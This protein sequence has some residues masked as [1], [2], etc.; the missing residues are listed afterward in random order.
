M[1]AVVQR[2]GNAEVRVE[3]EVVGAIQEGLVVLLGVGEDDEMKDAEYLADKI[4]GLR[5]FP[6]SGDK[7][8]LSIAETGG[9]ILAISQFTLFG[10]C[11]K[12]RRPSFDAA[13]NPTK[14]KLLY[15][16]FIDKVRSKGI[17]VECGKFQA[18]MSVRLE[19]RGPVTL[20]I[21]SKRTF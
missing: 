18:E 12:G 13:A 9:A 17:T 6:D 2:S 14:A 21:D 19:N 15:E 4:S 10:D 7:M 1:R 11:R 5:I 16:A 8:N 20:I 3:E